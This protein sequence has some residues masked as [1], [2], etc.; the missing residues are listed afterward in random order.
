MCEMLL[1]LPLSPSARDFRLYHVLLGYGRSQFKNLDTAVKR[2]VLMISMVK[3]STVLTHY[4]KGKS[5]RLAT[6]MILI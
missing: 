6:L 3:N 2:I 5:T 4:A 1:S